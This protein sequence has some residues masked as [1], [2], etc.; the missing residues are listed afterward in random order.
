MMNRM[1]AD[2]AVAVLAQHGVAA[3]SYRMGGGVYVAATYRDDVVMTFIHDGTTGYVAE[4]TLAEWDG[5]SMDEPTTV[6]EVEL[7]EFRDIMGGRRSVMEDIAEAMGGRYTRPRHIVRNVTIVRR[8]TLPP[9][10]IRS[11][12]TLEDLSAHFGATALEGGE[13]RTY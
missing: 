13:R 7:L 5:E 2:V 10:V 4:H 3:E 6:L 11:A 9:I 8:G 1:Q 12:A